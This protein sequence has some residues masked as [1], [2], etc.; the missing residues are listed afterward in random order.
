MNRSPRAWALALVLLA[1]L[2]PGTAAAAE[3][4]DKSADSEDKTTESTDKSAESTDKAIECPDKPAESDEKVAECWDK[5]NL[6]LPR[7]QRGGAWN[8][9]LAYGRL[10]DER[11]NRIV[12]GDTGNF[13]EEDLYTID[14][15]YTLKH[16]NAFMRFMDPVVTNISVAVN[17]TYQ[18]DPA[19]NII[20]ISPYLMFRWSNFPWS[21]Y[22]RTT[23]AYGGGLSW[24]SQIPQSEYDPGIPDGSYHNILH[25][26]AIEAT[27]ALPKYDEWQLVYRLHHRSGIFGLMGADNDGTTA[28]EVGV[29]YFFE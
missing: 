26:I 23:F 9:L 20:E 3:S 22:V 14:V 2:G 5:Y 19:G 16:D 21:K 17:L 8:A 27:L 7:D 15:A 4:T 18:D 11:L 29:R 13:T 12:R 28:M 1:V 24:A 25:Y 6:S 10:S